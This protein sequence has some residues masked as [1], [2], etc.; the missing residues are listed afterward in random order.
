MSSVMGGMEGDRNIGCVSGEGALQRCGCRPE[1]GGCQK[2]D[3]MLVGYMRGLPSDEDGLL[4]QR[5]LLQDAG[6]ERVVEDVLSGG[7]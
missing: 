3:R 2:D 1:I 4:A 5:R 7:R 6:C